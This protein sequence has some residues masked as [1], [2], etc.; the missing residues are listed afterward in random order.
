MYTCI[1]DINTEIIRYVRDGGKPFKNSRKKVLEVLA[2]LS[3][4]L[5]VS[6]CK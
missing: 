3:A 2:A 6:N 5:S 4:Y 1:T